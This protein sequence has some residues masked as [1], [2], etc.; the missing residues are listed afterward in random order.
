MTYSQDRT[1]SRIFWQIGVAALSRLFLNTAR[2]FAYPFAPAL[3]R[4][5]GISLTAVTSLIAINQVTGVLGLVFGPLGDRWGYRSMMLAGLSL[6]TI[7]MVTGGVFPFYGSILM[8]FF[9]AGL[10]KTIFDPALQAY[11]GSQIPYERRGMVIGIVE[12]SWAGSSLAGIPLIGLLIGHFGWRSPFLVLGG[13]GVLSI[14]GLGMLTFETQKSSAAHPQPLHLFQSWR[15]LGLKRSALGALCFAFFIAAANDNLFV[16]YGVWLEQRFQLGIV[17]LGIA[18]T[19]VGVAELLGD[20]LTASLADRFKLTRS[21]L[22]GLVLSGASYA[23]LPYLG[24]S[25][26]FALG[27]LFLVY[28]T[29]EFTVVT[30]MSLFTEFLPQ[31]RATMMSGFF[32]ASSIG[33]VCGALIGGV[34]WGTGGI[35]AT[36][37]ASAFISGLGLI[38]LFLGLRHWRPN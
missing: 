22:V 32:A 12:I 2:R 21:V 11:V 18:T 28:L 31:A 34:V 20:G 10:G 30:S 24:Y 7:G 16:V 8:A 9:L 26:S 13:L 37:M 5:M 19:I 33:R 14:V 15:Q 1:A 27:G 6:L 17:D 38:S 29:F 3:S 4:G 35:M 23:A 25:L 36:A